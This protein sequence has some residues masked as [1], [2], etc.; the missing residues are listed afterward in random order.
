MTIFNIN[1]CGQDWPL[2]FFTHHAQV[3]G[4][5]IMDAFTRMSVPTLFNELI[6]PVLA[7]FLSVQI[8]KL[9]FLAK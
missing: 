8:L 6:K 5:C 3:H 9:D 7:A 4:S 1:F 2:N